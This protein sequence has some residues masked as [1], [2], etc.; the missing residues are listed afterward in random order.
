MDS[1]DAVSEGQDGDKG[2]KVQTSASMASTVKEPENE[3]LEKA[4]NSYVHALLSHK[5][6]RGEDEVS[7]L[8]DL[9]KKFARQE[10]ENASLRQDVEKSKSDS[11][12]LKELKGRWKH[13]AARIKSYEDTI[14]KYAKSA[15][16]CKPIIL[17]AIESKWYAELG[18]HD[19]KERKL[20]A[21]EKAR[22]DYKELFEV[23]DTALSKK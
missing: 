18:G 23:S 9:R 3:T 6:K 21:A 22:A 10:K 13:F 20:L 19:D 5:R 8:E 17:D 15:E 14:M 1:G 4:R 11:E 16:A 7:E 12:L 2:S